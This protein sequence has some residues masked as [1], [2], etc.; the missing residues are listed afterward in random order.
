MTRFAAL[1]ALASALFVATG[2]TDVDLQVWTTDETDGVP[3]TVSGDGLTCTIASPDFT[4]DLRLQ[5]GESA[6]EADVVAVFAPV[7]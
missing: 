6:E 3:M 5:M 7:E 4:S 1:T 2:C